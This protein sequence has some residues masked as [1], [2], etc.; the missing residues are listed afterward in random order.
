MTG[1]AKWLALLPLA[2]RA[3][4]V[5]TEPEGGW[6]QYHDD[7]KY[8]E[9]K[10]KK[11]RAER[12]E[13]DSSNSGPDGRR[14]RPRRATRSDITINAL[15]DGEVRYRTRRATFADLPRRGSIPR[16]EPSR[17]QEE[18]PRR[19]QSRADSRSRGNRGDVGH[20]GAMS[21]DSE[22][23]R[24][25]RFSDEDDEK[26]IVLGRRGSRKHRQSSSF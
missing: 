15:G 17:K 2:L 9:Y 4:F 11:R 18:P 3:I 8:K 20:D 24:R 26:P 21:S 5:L 23:Y 25:P 22:G 6:E 14:E 13:R 12:A 10:D 7:K 16:N 1:Q 19:R